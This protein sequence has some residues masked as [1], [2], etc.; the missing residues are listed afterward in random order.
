MGFVAVCGH[1][2]GVVYSLHWGWF[3]NF[4]ATVGRSDCNYGLYFSFF[5]LR[6]KLGFLHSDVGAE[7][8]T[9]IFGLESTV[10]PMYLDGRQLF[11]VLVALVMLVFPVQN[12]QCTAEFVAR[13]QAALVTMYC[14]SL[15]WKVVLPTL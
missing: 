15:T 3:R 6:L 12:M 11:L 9:A 8:P 13:I 10:F 1:L 5:Y 14:P 7:L 4:S 2:D